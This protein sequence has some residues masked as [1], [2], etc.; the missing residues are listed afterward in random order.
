[1][2]IRIGSIAEVSGSH[3]KDILEA[4]FKKYGLSTSG[5][6]KDGILMGIMHPSDV[7]GERSL[8][9]GVPRG[10]T[11]IARGKLELLTLDCANFDSKSLITRRCPKVC[12][13]P[14][15]YPSWF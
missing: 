11:V 6:N 9:K 1:M 10:A 14:R 15:Q 7:F 3:I 5:S 12:T 13:R 4:Q 2:C 8:L